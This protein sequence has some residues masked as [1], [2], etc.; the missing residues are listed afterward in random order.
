MLAGLTTCAFIYYK[1]ETSFRIIWITLS[2]ISLA[3]SIP[4]AKTKNKRHS[5]REFPYAKTFITASIWTLAT[6][7][8]HLMDT[9]WDI[10]ET[11]GIVSSFL[12]LLALSM[13]FDIRDY[14]SDKQQQLITVPVSMGIASSKRLMI[15]S[16]FLSCILAY[17]HHQNLLCIPHILAATAA[18]WII[19]F[20]GPQ[21]KE[22]YFSGLIDGTII[23][24]AV[25]MIIGKAIIK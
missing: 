25:L 23:M 22:P 1:A 12:F 24:Y 6:S 11:T 3:Y 18:S 5:L 10:H 21:K 9:A 7:L 8:P 4:L 16:L 20:S 2:I 15:A 19:R 13:A 14:D 17:F